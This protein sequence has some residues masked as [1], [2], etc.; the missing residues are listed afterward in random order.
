MRSS[1]GCGVPAV[2]LAGF[3]LLETTAFAQWPPAAPQQQPYPA[4]PSPPVGQPQAPGPIL[5]PAPGAPQGPSA[6]PREAPTPPGLSASPTRI[7]SEKFIVNYDPAAWVKDSERISPDGKRF[8]V[9]LQAQDKGTAYA[10]I[11]GRNQKTYAWARD[12]TFSGDSR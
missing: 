9:V 3:L 4:A 8:A 1:F 11:D 7:E 5:L 6:P 2:L 10:S 12:L